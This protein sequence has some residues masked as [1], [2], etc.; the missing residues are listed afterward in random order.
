MRR[1][2]GFLKKDS[3]FLLH[4]LRTVLIRNGDQDVRN[5]TPYGALIVKQVEHVISP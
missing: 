1:V 2:D 4:V 3:Y 5:G